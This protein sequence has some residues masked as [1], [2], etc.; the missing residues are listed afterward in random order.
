MVCRRTSANPSSEQ[1]CNFVNWTLRNKFQWYIDRNSCIFIQ[2][3]A[4]TIVSGKWQPSCLG[5]NV[6]RF[7]VAT[8]IHIHDIATRGTPVSTWGCSL[9]RERFSRYCGS[10]LQELY[11]QFL[12]C[13]VLFKFDVGWFLHF[14]QDN[15]ITKCK[16]IDL[17]IDHG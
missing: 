17:V 3:N 13:C 12:F 6:V 10:V 16:L 11:T 8:V 1:C 5:L 9:H 15:S 7:V 2:E 4:F 14:Q